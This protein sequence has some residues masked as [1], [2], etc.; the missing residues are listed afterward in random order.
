MEVHFYFIAEPVLANIDDVIFQRRFEGFGKV[1]CV[2]LIQYVV[3][4]AGKAIAANAAVVF[5][6]IS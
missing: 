2:I 4:G 1:F 5:I 3:A 6:F